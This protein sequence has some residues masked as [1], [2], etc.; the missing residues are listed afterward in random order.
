MLSYCFLDIW[1]TTPCACHSKC[2]HGNYSLHKIWSTKLQMPKMTLYLIRPR[3]I[4]TYSFSNCCA[5]IYGD[6]YQSSAWNKLNSA[7]SVHERKV[8]LWLLKVPFG[9]NYFQ[10][11][12]MH[13]FLLFS[14]TYYP[15][16]KKI[17]GKFRKDFHNN[18]RLSFKIQHA[19][20]ELEGKIHWCSSRDINA[21]ARSQI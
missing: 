3:K 19:A 10:N 17:K 16:H 12:N 6:W 8:M 2:M 5:Q 7:V 9:I 4:W 21:L 20:N 11:K 18:L 14:C 1:A 13:C 15:L